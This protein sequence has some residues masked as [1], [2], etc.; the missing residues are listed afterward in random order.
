MK[1]NNRTLLFK[2]LTICLSLLLCCFSA[3]CSSFSKHKVE[4]AEEIRTETFLDKPD[5]IIR[6]TDGNENRLSVEVSETVYNAFM[7]LMNALSQ[8]SALKTPFRTKLINEWKSDYACFEFRYTR[9]RNYV[10]ALNDEN[11]MFSWGELKFDAFLF[12]CYSGGLIAVPYIGNNYTGIN[13]L[14]LFLNFPEEEMNNFINIL[15]G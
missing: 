11:D 7:D 1:R 10:G 4:N 14:F 5:Y 2:T 13:D 6:I 9:R 12:V 8:T 3:G 15:R